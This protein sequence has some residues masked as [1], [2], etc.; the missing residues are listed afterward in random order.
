[1]ALSEKAVDSQEGLPCTEELQGL[2]GYINYLVL[3][4]KIQLIIS[5]VFI[6]FHTL[7][8]L[9]ADTINMEDGKLELV[10]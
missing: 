2:S 6:F 7:V 8:H 1:L 5:K 9:V 4:I 10:E 3:T